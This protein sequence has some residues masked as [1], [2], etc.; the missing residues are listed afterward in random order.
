MEEE[1]DST[2]EDDESRIGSLLSDR[3]KRQVDDDL[4]FSSEAA[5]IESQSVLRVPAGVFI[6]QVTPLFSIIFDQA[7]RL[8]PILS[9]PDSLAFIHRCGQG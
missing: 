6:E 1:E 3:T 9:L 7:K 8:T 2:V 4:E 5:T